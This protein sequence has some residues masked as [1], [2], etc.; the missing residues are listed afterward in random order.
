MAHLRF[1]LSRLAGGEGWSH[2]YIP[3]LKRSKY[4][5]VRLTTAESPCFIL[6]PH[7][8]SSTEP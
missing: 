6:R 4:L 8:P 2:R 3:L 1:G 7:L 5:R